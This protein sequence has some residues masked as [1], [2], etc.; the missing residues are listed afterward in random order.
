MTKYRYN[1]DDINCGDT[2]LKE[3]SVGTY[4]MALT[5]TQANPHMNGVSSF[6][7]T[8]GRIYYTYWY[9]IPPRFAEV[10]SDFVEYSDLGL[11]WQ[12]VQEFDSL[13]ATAL[14][15]AEV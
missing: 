12:E 1:S 14:L 10:T 11:L 8:N 5:V 6:L 3:H 9:F 4:W 13:L 15:H 2:V 7:H